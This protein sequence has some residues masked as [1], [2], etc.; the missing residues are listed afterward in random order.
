MRRRCSLVQALF[1]F[2]NGFRL[3]LIAELLKQWSVDRR[4]AKSANS[5]KDRFGSSKVRTRVLDDATERFE[6][7]PL[8]PRIPRTPGSSGR[9]PKSDTTRRACR[10]SCGSGFPEIPKDPMESTRDGSRIRASHDA[11]QER[12]I[13]NCSV[14]L[15]H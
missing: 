11:Q 12:C 14:P 4:T 10:E 5:Q 15:D 7:L 3:K 6:G 8:A 13:T 2:F 9:P 1:D